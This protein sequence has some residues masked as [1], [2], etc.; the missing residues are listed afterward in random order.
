MY[1][2]SHFKKQI[3]DTE[4][5]LVKEFGQIRTGR[6]TPTILDGVTVEAYGSMVPISNVATISSEDARTLRITPWDNGNI[7]PIEKAIQ[8]SNLGLSVAVDDKGLRVSFPSLT[9]E[10]RGNFVKIAKQKLEDA[11]IALRQERN[12]VNDELNAGKKD[13]TMSEDDV[14]R[15]RTEVDKLI[16]EGTEKLEGHTKK[17]EEEILG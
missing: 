15:A 7:K 1:D 2:F 13:G 6:A 12:K 16:K 9:T 17:K 4:D 5:W 3:K 10:S 8:I 14:M 11:K